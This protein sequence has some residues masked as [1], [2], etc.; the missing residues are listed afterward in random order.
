[1]F[2]MTVVSDYKKFFEK[3]NLSEEEIKVKKLFEKM[4]FDYLGIFDL[5]EL[6]FIN[7]NPS[8][9]TCIGAEPDEEDGKSYLFIESIEIEKGLEEFPN[10]YFRESMKLKKIN[11]KISTLEFALLHELG[12]FL[13]YIDNP[14][15]YEED[16]GRSDIVLNYIYKNYTDFDNETIY[17][18]YQQIDMEERADI[19]AYAMAEVLNRE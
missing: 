1:M 19:N 5:V 8:I 9:G 14:D 11:P 13:D 10:G 6:V 3:T 7:P 12:H 16:A 2:G 15:R 17:Y 18:L 4:Q